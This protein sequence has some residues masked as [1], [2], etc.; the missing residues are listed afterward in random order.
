MYTYGLGVT[1]DYSQAFKWL[2]KAAT[3]GNP[4]AQIGMGSLYK[5]GWGVRKDCYIAMTWYLRSVA[6]G[7]TDAMNNIGYLYKTDLGSP[8]TLKKL[9]FGLKKQQIRIIR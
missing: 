6:H 7:N 2:N 3:Q 9:F 5:N 1:K 8:K 4:E